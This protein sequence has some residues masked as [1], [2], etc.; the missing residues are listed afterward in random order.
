MFTLYQIAFCANTKSYSLY[1][2]VIVAWI[3]TLYPICASPL[4]IRLVLHSFAPL[5]KSHLLCVIRR[6]PTCKSSMV[7]IPEQKVSSI[8][9]LASQ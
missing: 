8:V 3:A 2:Y 6:S 9:N 1:M 5:Q 7:F 4:Y